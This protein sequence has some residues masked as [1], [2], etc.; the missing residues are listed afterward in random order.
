MLMKAVEERVPVP[1]R[2]DDMWRQGKGRI[3][4]LREGG[5]GTASQGGSGLRRVWQQWLRLC[6]H[7]SWQGGRAKGGW[8]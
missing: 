2:R 6:D 1:V 4:R 7:I 3:L 8:L 5:L